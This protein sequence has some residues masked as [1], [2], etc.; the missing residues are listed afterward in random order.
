M[1]K[2]KIV[3]FIASALITV[4]LVTA[5]QAAPAP[6]PKPS[7][8]VGTLVDFCRT[9]YNRFQKGDSSYLR[10]GMSTLSADQ[11]NVVA[12]VCVAYGEGFKDGAQRKGINIA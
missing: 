12:L 4:S 9:A 6:S 2:H 5:V 8:V 1:I 10:N 11:R 7:E 3:S